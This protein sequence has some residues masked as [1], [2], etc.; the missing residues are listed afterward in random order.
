MSLKIRNLVKGEELPSSLAA[1]FEKGNQPD[2]L[3]VAERDGK[4]VAILVAAP[5]HIVAILLRIASTDEAEP[6]DMRVL[7]VN[8][9]KDI[10]ARGFEGY[11]TW[12]N[13]DTGV[14]KKLHDIIMAG[15]GIQ[16][17][18]PMFFC[19]GRF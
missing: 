3:W 11:V 19:V 16:L 17:P 13:P 10:K 2:W 7:L 15:G 6:M 14:E 18:Q 1:G 4:I 12:L 8:A 9:I 5:A